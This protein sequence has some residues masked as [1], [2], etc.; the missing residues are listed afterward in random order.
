MG[1]RALV[2]APTTASIPNT[3]KIPST[4]RALVKSL[5]RLSR[6][7]LIKLALEWLEDDNQITCA[8]YLASNRDLQEEAEE[9][10]FHTP[11]DTL[12]ELRRLYN[13]FKSDSGS[14]RDVV[15]R[16]LDGDWRRGLSLQQLAMV[17]FQHLEEH[18]ASLRWSALK[19]VPL[20]SASKQDLSGL[21]TQSRPRSSAQFPRIQPSTFLRALQREIGPLV[22]AHYY[23]HRMPAPHSLTIL[24]LYIC[25]TPYSTP[26]SSSQA[27]F[28]DAARTMYIA[29]PDSCPFIYVAVSG[30]SG[31]GGAGNNKAGGVPKTDMALLKRTVL[32]GI[33]KA[34]SQPQQ[35]YAMEPTSLIAKN[36]STM[37]ELRGNGRGGASLG[38]YS[39]FADGSAEGNPLDT[40]REIFEGRVLPRDDKD[41]TTSS[42]QNDSRS[43]ERS[44]KRKVLGDRDTNTITPTPGPSSGAE[45][46]GRQAK[47]QKTAV[48]CRFGTTGLANS[49]INAPLD[50]VQFKIEDELARPQRQRTTTTTT[51]TTTTVR[52]GSPAG[53]QIT[54]SLTFHGSDVFAGLRRLAEREPESVDLEHWPSW[55][56][57]EEGVSVGTVRA[58]VMVDGRGGGG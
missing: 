28:S 29:F 16:I 25:D 11:A 42:G 19:L 14:K 30:S 34:L 45:K 24:R 3:Y 40:N 6:I 35:R 54:L 10:Y 15:D 13:S 17:D 47:K 43:M 18:E 1:P 52:D 53:S 9:D 31:G 4:T 27:Y 57:G 41:N 32:E 26:L 55:M 36:L 2:R 21:K 50:R 38:A 20:A 44:S 37:C 46:E 23:L 22:K 49:K 5:S 39:V 56:T 7:S 51:T 58:G 12:Q 8:P 48:A 33:P